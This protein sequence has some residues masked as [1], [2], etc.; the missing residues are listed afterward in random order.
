MGSSEPVRPPGRRRPPPSTPAVRAVFPLALPVGLEL[1]NSFAPAGGAPAP[2]DTADLTGTGAGSLVRRPRC[3]GCPAVGG[4]RPARG[5]RAL[6]DPPP[7]HSGC[8]GGCP[9]RCSPPP[10]AHPRG[11]AV[12][13]I[14]H[15][16]VGIDNGCAALPVR[17]LLGRWGL[18]HPVHRQGLLRGHGAPDYE[19]WAPLVAPYLG[20]PHRRR[21]NMID[22]VRALRH[23][24]PTPRRTGWAS[25]TPRA[26]RPAGPPPSS[27]PPTPRNCGCSGRWPP[28]RPPTSA[29]SRKALAG[30]LTEEQLLTL[31][32]ILEAQSRCI[33]TWTSTTSGRARPPS[34]GV[35]DRLRG[36][37]LYQR[38]RAAEQLRPTDLEP[39][40]PA[41]ADRLRRLLQDG[42][43]RSAAVRPR[44]RSGTAAP[45]PWWTPSGPPPRVARACEM[46]GTVTIQF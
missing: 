12:V 46:G 31:P 2:G 1:V 27:P 20:R 45:T 37:L 24:F 8:R 42:R 23:T 21:L 6:T 28:H 41:A 11:L 19:G 38:G 5:P 14:G 44:C 39:R 32:L 4:R 35:R 25:G 16:T 34:S 36:P 29:I 13:A 43:C 18:R 9:D 26:V 33:P 7:A 40:T 17:K 3:R 30:T 22:S 15:G 10:A